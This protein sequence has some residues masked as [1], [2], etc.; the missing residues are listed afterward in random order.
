MY[1][2]GK[3]ILY[4]IDKEI[5]VEGDNVR[6]TTPEFTVVLDHRLFHKKH[7]GKP[8]EVKKEMKKILFS[9]YWDILY[10]EY[11]ELYKEG[12]N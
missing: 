8:E 6:V 2:L 11:R 4:C 9:F 5:E 3:F 7:M 12:K 10:V 1:S